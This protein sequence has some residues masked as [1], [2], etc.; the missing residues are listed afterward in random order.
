MTEPRGSE[1]L[2]S[3]EWLAANLE[4]AGRDFVLIDAGEAVAYRRVHIP[5]AVGVPHPY[6]KSDDDPAYVMSAAA[7]EALAGG[8]GISNEMPV[9]VYDESA[10]LHSARVWW[11]FNH[12]GHT[13]VRVVDG[14]F[15]A[16][17]E[18]GR[19]LTSIAPRPA[20]ASFVAQEAPATACSLDELKATVEAGSGAQ[21]WDLRADGEWTGA[22]LRGNTRGGHVPGAQHLVW[23]QLVQGP[24][25]RRFRPLDEIEAQLRAA[26]IDPTAPTVTYC[27]L[28][29]RAAFG[30]FVLRLLGNDASRTYDGSMNEWANRLD[31]P[32]VTEV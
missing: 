11:V 9:I 8:L 25:M 2:V 30:N 22:D 5:G 14:G 26:G 28:G 24:P 15:N 4:G 21:I 3:T 17:L 7:F 12:F 19:A 18:E 13:N 27:E 1:L 16:W 29:I 10:S 32:L 31:T 23:R 6:L 20:R